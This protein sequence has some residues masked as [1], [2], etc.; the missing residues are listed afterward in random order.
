MKEYKLFKFTSV[1]KDQFDDPAAEVYTV[2]IFASNLLEAVTKFKQVLDADYIYD[3]E[4]D[5][6]TITCEDAIY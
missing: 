1:S 6:L 2:N 3:E 5:L 4:E